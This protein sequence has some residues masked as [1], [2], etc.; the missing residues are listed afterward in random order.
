[1]TCLLLS[2]FQ[3][4]TRILS[5]INNPTLKLSSLFAKST[6]KV[7]E[8]LVSSTPF[9]TEVKELETQISKFEKEM[10]N[11]KFVL[12]LILQKEFYVSESLIGKCT[13]K[14]Q[15]FLCSLSKEELK[16][17]KDVLQQ[18]I[19]SMEEQIALIGQ[20]EIL[21]LQQESAIASTG[22]NIL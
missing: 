7:I 18:R 2:F 5:F 4:A 20:K 6:A 8:T 13:N 11:I 14:Q 17:N 19:L 22:E 3:F 1:M 15:R 21:L 12:N 9:A 10:R 16:Q